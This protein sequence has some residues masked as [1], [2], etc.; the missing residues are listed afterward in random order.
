[1][2]RGSLVHKG[3]NAFYAGELR[4]WMEGTIPQIKAQ[5]E[6]VPSNEREDYEE[7]LALALEALP[8]YVK[9]A[10]VNDD[11]TVKQSELKA[12]VAMPAPLEQHEFQ[13]EVD[14]V[15]QRP[16]GTIWIQ[17][18]KTAKVP[19]H[20]SI[21]ELD[22]QISAYV[23]MLPQVLEHEV[24]GL[25]YTQIPLKTLKS[26]PYGGMDVVRY[27]LHR[28]PDQIARFFEEVMLQTAD[29][30]DAHI[31]RSPDMRC[32]WDCHF[33]QLCRIESQGGDADAL[34]RSQFETGVP[35]A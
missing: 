9:W 32:S 7:E 22:P 31:Y 11:Y 18:Y 26:G 13:F 12:K 24:T 27:Y 29:M 2:A 10:R 16:D 35:D 23:T 1:M 8:R 15:V 4:D 5:L 34:R 30:V 14:A 20:E 19:L 21:V 28:T 25:I 3:I 6:K 33:E 17:E